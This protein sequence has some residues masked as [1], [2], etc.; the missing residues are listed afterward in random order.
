MMMFDMLTASKIVNSDVTTD[1]NAFTEL[2]R[3]KFGEVEI[4]PDAHFVLV[5][6]I[7]DE[8]LIW[9]L[10]GGQISREHI[11]KEEAD[12]LLNRFGVSLYQAGKN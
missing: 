6:D 4:A 10:S 8:Y 5:P 1:I 7:D 3:S 11:E 9:M 12:V 2:L